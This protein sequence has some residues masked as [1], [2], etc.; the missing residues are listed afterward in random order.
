MRTVVPRFTKTPACHD[1][2]E[3]EEQPSRQAPMRNA[4]RTR[5]ARFVVP[6]PPSPAAPTQATPAKLSCPVLNPRRSRAFN[7]A[8]APRQ[9]LTQACAPGQPLCGLRGVEHPAS[10]AGKLDSSGSSAATSCPSFGPQGRPQKGV[11]RSR[12]T[13]STPPPAARP[14]PCFA[15]VLGLS[16]QRAQ[17]KVVSE[18]SHGPP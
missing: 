18:S 11:A 16:F 12:G 15:L 17:E 10:Q 2:C 1:G 9:R 4:A 13:T 5:R 3:D 7:A 8:H 6:P 14:E